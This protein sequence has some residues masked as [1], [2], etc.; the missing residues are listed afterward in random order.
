MSTN[1]A[2]ATTRPASAWCGCTASRAHSSARL[3]RNWSGSNVHSASASASAKSRL[4]IGRT[5][6]RAGSSVPSVRRPRCC[7]AASRDAGLAHPRRARRPRLQRRRPSTCPDNEALRYGKEFGNRGQC[8][9][10]YFTVGNLVKY[11]VRAARREGHDHRG[12]RRAATSSSRPAR[13]GRAASACTSPSTARRCATPASTG[14][15]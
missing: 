14:S 9:P 8:N 13:A 2:E 3:R 15:A 1:R 10:T 11:L 5:R 7:S 12:H 6:I 4:P